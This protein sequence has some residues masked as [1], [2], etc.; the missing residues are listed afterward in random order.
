MTE[1]YTDSSRFCNLQSSSSSSSEKDIAISTMKKYKTEALDND[2]QEQ[3]IQEDQQ[4]NGNKDEEIEAI[5]IEDQDGVEQAKTDFEQ[6]NSLFT[7]NFL[8]DDVPT[9]LDN[10]TK[11]QESQEEMKQ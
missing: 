6:Q 10:S 1:K 5:K 7:F 8:N 3:V 9:H 11:N 2:V 4:S